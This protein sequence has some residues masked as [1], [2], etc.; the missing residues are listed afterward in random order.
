MDPE[1]PPGLD[2]WA[3]PVAEDDVVGGGMMAVIMEA[4]DREAI[5]EATGVIDPEA[6]LLS[7]S[8]RVQVDLELATLRLDVQS[9]FLQYFTFSSSF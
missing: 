4:E 2:P 7:G 5:S 8:P 9:V 3:A 6:G 1:T